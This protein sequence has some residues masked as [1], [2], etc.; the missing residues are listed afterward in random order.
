MTKRKLQTVEIFKMLL[1]KGKITE[2]LIHM[3]MK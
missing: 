1:S 2:D 3:L